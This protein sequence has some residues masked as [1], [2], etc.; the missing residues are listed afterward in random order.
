LNVDFPV[1][2]CAVCGFKVQCVYTEVDLLSDSF[3]IT[4]RCHG[5]VEVIQ[6]P[7]RELMEKWTLK[8]DWTAFVPALPHKGVTDV[9]ARSESR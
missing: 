5:A 7:H 2:T 6:I 8:A 1:P 4:V 3:V 9:V